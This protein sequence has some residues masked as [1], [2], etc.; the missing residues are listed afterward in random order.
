MRPSPFK[1][2]RFFAQHEFGAPYVLSAS[3]CEPLALAD[4]LGMAD[5]ESL[6]LWQDLRLGYT[7]S[8]GHPLLRRE[9]ARTYQQVEP[10]DVSLVVPEEG[11]LLT[12]LASLNAGDHV[13]AICPA[14]Q[15]LYEIARS[16]GCR[17]TRW[18]PDEGAGWQYRLADLEAQIAPDTR[19]IVINFPHNPTGATIAPSTFDALLQMAAERGIRVFSDEMY[20]LLEYEGADRLPAAVDASPTAISLSGMSK[21]YA[22]AGLRIG[23]LATRDRA[24][25]QRL[26][27]L[28]DYTTICASAPSEILALMGLRAGEHIIR[29][30]LG[31]ICGNLARFERFLEIHTEL[32][33]QRP[34]AGTVGFARLLGDLPVASFCA[35][36]REQAGVLLTPGELFDW[37]G[38]H[39]R[40]GLGRANLPEALARLE[41]F[42]ADE[43]GR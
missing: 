26:A 29:R 3:D 35:R 20:R 40:I 37:G 18:M 21:V 41:T 34:R 1:L 17:V 7:E 19:L 9:I 15:S 23:W 6:A 38:N 5:P 4:L 27:Y 22:L 33:W 28:K 10:D 8:Q 11:I 31:I 13:I 43:A 2:E 14:Y 16:L 32:A 24:L 25:M 12:M 39:L 30:N 36:A 42:L